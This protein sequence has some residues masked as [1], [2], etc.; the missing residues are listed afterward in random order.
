MLIK[1]KL[2]NGTV[3]IAFDSF[4]HKYTYNGEGVP[5]VTGILGIINKPAL[6]N[7]AAG[8]AAD[9]I[10]ESLSPGVSYDEL[11]LQAIIE[12]GRKAHWQKKI[13]AGNIGTFL[14][15]W[16]EHYIKG[17]SPGM[18][19]N[20]NLKESVNKF[21]GWTEK[22]K[23]KFILS[24]QM[25]YSVKYK[26]AGTLDF[27]CTIDGKLYL[28]DTKTSSG[29]YPEMLV[30]TSA[31]RFARHEEFPDENYHGQLIL[32]IGKDGEFEFAVMRDTAIYQDMFRAFLAAQKLSSTME[33]LKSF[34]TDKE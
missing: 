32:R 29:I 21:L 17:E 15:Q 18:P 6:V 33:M 25:V 26:Y 24:E 2:Y 14:H 1:N 30:Q 11:Q 9:S 23:V 16:I 34:K 20:E 13:D 5:T 19:V 12:A 7:W 4:K 22:H 31:Y 3:E 27:V 10:A 8:C 28:G